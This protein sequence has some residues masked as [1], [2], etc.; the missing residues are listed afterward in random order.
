MHHKFYALVA[1]QLFLATLAEN[2]GCYKGGEKFSNLGSSMDISNA[3]N[4][5]CDRIGGKQYML[6]EKVSS[7]I[8]H[9]PV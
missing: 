7:K 1:T 2:P 5:I 9:S 8:K 3:F 6:G 4:R